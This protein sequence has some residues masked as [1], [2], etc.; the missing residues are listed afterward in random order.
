MCLV[1]IGISGGEM[2][3]LSFASELITNI[4]LLFVDEATSGLD[5]YMALNVV[6]CMRKLTEQ[7]KTIICTIHQPSSEI[8][9]MFDNLCLMAQGR[10]AYIGSS[11]EAENFFIR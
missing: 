8:F 10:I 3:R 4:E 9:E 1:T 6:E 2:K 5:S 7:G 11:R